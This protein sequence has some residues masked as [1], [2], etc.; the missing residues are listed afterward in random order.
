MAPYLASCALFLPIFL[1]FMDLLRW[2]NISNIIKSSYWPSTARFIK[3]YLQVPHPHTFWRFP[4]MMIP[5]LPW[6]ALILFVVLLFVPFSFVSLP[7]TPRNVTPWPYPLSSNG[8][9]K[10][11]PPGDW[12]LSL[13]LGSS[14]YTWALQQTDFHAVLMLVPQ[15][16]AAWMAES[17]YSCN[18]AAS[19]LTEKQ[20]GVHCLK[21][22][23][24]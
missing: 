8:Q 7:S 15:F 13:L 3:S 4:R 1:M 5:P 21:K 6:A 14:P 23:K 9:H 11:K 22:S 17:A 24:L 10:V 18:Q 16:K 19:E 2:E 20:S 12:V